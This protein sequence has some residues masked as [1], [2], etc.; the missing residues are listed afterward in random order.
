MGE[1]AT[2]PIVEVTCAVIVRDGLV[3]AARR[4][5]AMDLPGRWEFP[6]GKVEPGED[7][8]AC[9]V[10]EIEEELGVTVAITGTLPPTIHA[11]PGARIRLIP[12]LARLVRG[13]PRPLEHDRIRWL[14]PEDLPRLDWAPADL[15]VVDACREL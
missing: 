9:L 15:P 11:Y 2:D 8:A 12:F 5:A 3:L 1:G 10:R 14:P 7:P 6:G 4:S 13:E